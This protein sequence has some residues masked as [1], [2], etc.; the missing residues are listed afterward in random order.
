MHPHEPK[1]I[2]SNDQLTAILLRL[3]T[4]PFLPVQ[5]FFF[6]EANLRYQIKEDF[7]PSVTNVSQSNLSDF[8]EN[9]ALC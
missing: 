3:C 9:I 7:L 8:S 2:P 6:L 5:F 4:S 1:L